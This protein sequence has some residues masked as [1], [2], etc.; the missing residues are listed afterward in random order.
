M[1]LIAEFT[2]SSP[3]LA[4]LP[5]LQAVPGVTVELEGQIAT[6]HHHPMLVVW[7][8]GEDVAAFETSLEDDPT[9]ERATVIERLEDTRLYRIEISNAVQGVY[10]TYQ[11]LG[12]APLA[13]TGT[14]KGW[15]RRVRFPDRDALA[16]FRAFCVEI[17]VSFKL[18]RLYQP[19]VETDDDFG[20]TDCQR[21]ALQTAFQEGYFEVPRTVGLQELGDELDVSAQSVSERL[22]RG[23]SQVLS[24]TVCQRNRD[25]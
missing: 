9:V 7:V 14:S 24:A 3:R 20:L 17:D 21:Q 23:I 22:R 1:S 2:I 19:S 6:S 11:K 10:P 16:D 13:G 4:L 5:T 8:T 25:H 12:A 18:H 15:N